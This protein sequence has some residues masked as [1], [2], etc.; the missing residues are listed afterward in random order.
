MYVV[1][2]DG[3]IFDSNVYIVRSGNECI[4]V[5]AGVDADDVVSHIDSD[6]AVK[7]IVLT[8]GHADH[9]ASV[10]QIKQITGALV[11]AHREEEELLKNSHYNCSD[12]IC[13]RSIVISPDILVDEGD[14]IDFGDT[15]L[16]FIH[17]PGHTR[18][19]MCIE[20]ENNLFTGDTLFCRA[21][22]RTDLPTGDGISLAK[23]V[24]KLRILKED[25]IVYPG[26]GVAT[27]IGEEKKYN[28]W[29]SFR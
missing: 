23:S 21:V 18:G 5:D 6:V 4:I 17:T 27:T 29:M 20:C 22:G 24:D 19:S 3:G 11:V 1:C 25:C 2:I 28:P 8:H 12:E 9:I 7:Y 10:V 13:Q 26:H 16:K 15:T 14:S